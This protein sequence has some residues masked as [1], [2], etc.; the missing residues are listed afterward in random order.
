MILLVAAAGFVAGEREDGTI[1][2][3]IRRGGDVVGEHEVS[4]AGPGE[5]LSITH[6]GFNRQIYARGAVSAALW[7]KDKGTGLYSM[8]DVLS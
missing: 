5:V 6:K 4:F 8:A 7:A 2:F 1:G 3:S